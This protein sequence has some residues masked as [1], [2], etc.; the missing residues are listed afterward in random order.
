LNIHKT[1]NSAL[2]FDSTIQR[3]LLNYK[4]LFSIT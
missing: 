1:N 3:G 2:A 4:L